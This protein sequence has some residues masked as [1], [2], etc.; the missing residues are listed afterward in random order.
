M[1]K[2][3]VLHNVFSRYCFWLTY[4]EKT[5]S[6]NYKLIQIKDGFSYPCFVR[7]FM[8]LSFPTTAKNIFNKKNIQKVLY[9]FSL[10]NK[11]LLKLRAI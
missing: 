4:I 1:W 2:V 9:L 5:S 10:P 8:T 3:Q 6:V 7:R 11:L